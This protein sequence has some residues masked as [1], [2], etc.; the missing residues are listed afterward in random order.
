MT[1]IDKHIEPLVDSHCHLDFSTFDGD[2][3]NIIIRAQKAGIKIMLTICTKPGDLEKVLKIA[4][5]YDSVY[6]ACG[7]H[8]LNIQEGNTF[9]YKQLI[10]LSHHPKM[11]GIGETGLDYF[12]SSD[13]AEPQKKSFALHIEIARRTKLPLIVH[14]RS[15][16]SDMIKILRREYKKE[17]FKCV[18]HCFSSGLELAN[19][20]IELGFYISISGIATFPKSIELRQILKGIP[21]DRILVET[22]SPYLAPVPFR[23]KRNEPAHVAK[24]AAFMSNFFNLELTD[25]RR[26][27]TKNFMRLF[28]KV[29]IE[30]KS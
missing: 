17:S 15:A 21:L 13:S 14:S 30:K 1:L 19:V 11:I 3:D 20:A 29:P 23:G 7:L 9:T 25:F 8:P 5:N 28:S 26:I 18:M 4:E 27:T 6:F 24:T 2:L 16:D 12:Y 22:D 10:D